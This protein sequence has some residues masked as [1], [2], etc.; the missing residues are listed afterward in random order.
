MFGALLGKKEQHDEK[1][2]LKKE[3]KEEK[4]E[5]K[6][7]EKAEEKAIKADVKKEE[8]AEK[9]AEKEERKE[10]KLLVKEEK[11]APKSDGVVEPKPLDAAAVGKN[12]PH[13]GLAP[14]IGQ[15]CSCHGQPS[16]S[17]RRLECREYKDGGTSRRCQHSCGARCHYRGA[18]GH[19]RG[20]ICDELHSARDCTQGQ[21]A[22]LNLWQ[23]LRQEGNSSSD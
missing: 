6:N 15:S 13:L 5:E 7:E 9:Q 19:Y 20:A 16:R 23:F 3:D 18:L 2:E 1:K 11:K 17:Y 10:E 8:K 12:D 22:E 21:Q 4:K 14:L